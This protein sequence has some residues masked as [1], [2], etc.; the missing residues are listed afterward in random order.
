M[1]KNCICCAIVLFIFISCKRDRSVS[2]K[3]FFIVDTSW[4]SR[5]YTRMNPCIDSVLY[6]SIKSY[7]TRYGGD[8]AWD[9]YSVYFFQ[10][11][12]M[13]YFTIWCDEVPSHYTMEYSNPGEKFNYY[14]FL[15]DEKYDVVLI[16]RQ[17]SKQPVLF[18][19]CI[20]QLG[21]FS[22]EDLKRKDQ[23]VIEV[24]WA[25]SYK[26]YSR[27]G[28][29]QVESLQ[30][31]ILW[32]FDWELLRQ[33]MDVLKRENQIMKEREKKKRFGFQV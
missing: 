11:D 4:I 29:Y 9:Y 16:V 7:I 22:V 28:K 8:P 26:Y 2:D 1:K 31:T 20:D 5:E 19:P 23:N 27:G 17:D 6:E 10:K 15:L 21:A 33:E 30:D 3:T 14:W 32:D 24:I 18:K 13:D 25:R 12:S